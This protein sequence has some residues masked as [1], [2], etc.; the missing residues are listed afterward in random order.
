MAAKNL[1]V[2]G[3]AFLGSDPLVHK[4]SR[5]AVGF[6]TTSGINDVILPLDTGSVTLL[7]V[8]DTKFVITD[9]AVLIKTAFSAAGNHTIGPNS[10]VDL[11]MSN[12]GPLAV[13]LLLTGYFPLRE[14]LGDTAATQNQAPFRTIEQRDTTIDVSGAV[15]AFVPFPVDSSDSIVMGYNSSGVPS[16]GELDLF[17]FYTEIA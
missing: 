14:I 10:S 12:A 8:S 1:P 6:D 15:L 16:N 9:L 11:W 4:V 13:D 7:T 17:V 3:E 5:I 2:V